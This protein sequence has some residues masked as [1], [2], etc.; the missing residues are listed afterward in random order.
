MGFLDF[1]KSSSFPP[2]ARFA[3]AMAIFVGVPPLCR[4]LRFPAAVGLLLSGIVIG[5]HGVGFFGEDHPIADFFA[6]LGKL[7][8][9]FFAGLEIDLSMLRR[10]QGRSVSFGIT[11]T[12]IPLLLGTG[13][14]LVFGYGMLTSLVLGS[15]LASHTLLGSPI[16]TALGGHRLE[17]MVV[18]TGATV[19]SDTLSLVVFAIALST[20]EAGFSMLTLLVQIAEI[21]VFVPLVLIGLS[22]LG[23]YLLE[24]ARGDE[25]AEF[26]LMLAIMAAAGLLAQVIHLPGIVGAFLAGLAVNAA[27]REC[28][29]REKMKLLGRALF[30][31]AFFVV[32]GFLIDPPTFLQGI[33]DNF[34]LVA[35]IV[36]ALITG[37]WIAAESVGRAFGYDADARATMW[38]L[39]L[40]QVAATLSAA[41]VAYDT[42]NA[43]GQRLIDRQL[44]EAV[45][46]LMVVTATLGPLLTQSFAPR[47]IARAGSSGAMSASRR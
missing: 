37:K 7:L 29:A 38:S 26:I 45:L 14:A 24:K 22:R 40:P 17:P 36:V 31:P 23:A 27:A 33:I 16:V 25:D 10:T 20:F 30:V 47:M 43:T 19:L 11:T 35:A 46:V 6:Q 15:L 2:L 32:T 34:P 39:T 1:L 21:A 13:V 28:A 4:R 41:L 12:V 9:M 44:L 42:L 5:P 8:L 18:T 3:L